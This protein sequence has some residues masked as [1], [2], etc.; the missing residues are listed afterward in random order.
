MIVITAPTS[1]IGRQV[2]DN[3]LDSTEAIRVVARD[4]NRLPATVRQRAEIIEGSHADR[5][6]VHRAFDGADSVFW[7]V[8][9]NLS[10]ES[11][12][13]AYVRFSIPAANA[14]VRHHVR[15]MV[16]ISS[17]GRHQQRY[18]G[19]ISASLAMDDL[20]RSTGAHLRALT[21]PSFMDNLLWQMHSIKDDGLISFTLPGNL[22][23]PVVATRDIAAV[24]SRLLLDHQWTGQDSLAVL[25]PENISFEEMAQI[26]SEV[27]DRPVRFVQGNRDDY[28]QGFVN[29]GYSDA[30][31]QGMVDMDIAIE[32]GLY[33]AM[34]GTSAIAGHTSFRQWAE[35]VFKPAFNA[36]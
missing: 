7:L 23:M 6:V 26:L 33:S 11:V 5:D 22:R 19:H 20:L 25:G 2:L 14:I 30:I 24:A 3:L 15:R 1:K 16:T 13:D 12:Y 29:R 10:S 27:L 21:M 31:A 28:K 34:R 35:E 9:A 18:A 8:P 17:L 36:L 4:P 32:Q